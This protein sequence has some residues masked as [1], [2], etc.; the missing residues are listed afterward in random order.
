MDDNGREEL[1]EV[2][3]ILISCFTFKSRA[4]TGKL[5]QRLFKSLTRSRIYIE[6]HTPGDA[7][8]DTSTKCVANLREAIYGGVGLN[9]N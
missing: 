5:W 6:Q 3:E 2:Y 1:R 8:V 4:I 9:L 7:K